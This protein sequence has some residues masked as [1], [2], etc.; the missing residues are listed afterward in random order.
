LSGF[1]INDLPILFLRFFFL[2]IAK[3]IAKRLTTGKSDP[4]AYVTS[5]S[6]PQ[7]VVRHK[8]PRTRRRQY[9]FVEAVTKLDHGLT[10]SDLHKAYQVAGNKFGSNLK[11]TFLVLDDGLPRC[12]PGAQQPPPG[13]V[14]EVAAGF[15]HLEAVGDGQSTSSSTR[16]G[17][18]T[19][20]SPIYLK[21]L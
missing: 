20:V 8:T 18:F 10:S 4:V 21:E 11:R 5:E 1:S 12:D 14:S 13:P 19:Q 9:G 15:A 2:F 16:K 6:R 3:A 17:Y 7:L